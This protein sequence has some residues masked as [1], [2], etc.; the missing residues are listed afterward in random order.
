MTSRYAIYFAPEPDSAFEQAGSLCLGR[1]ARTGWS[2]EPLPVAGIPKARLQVINAPPR[3]YGFHGTLKAP[4]HLN[5]QFIEANLVEAIDRLASQIDAFALPPLAVKCLGNFIA[6]VPQQESSD[7]RNLAER[8][9]S[10]LDAFRAPMTDSDRARRNP[11]RL[12]LQQRNNLDRWGYPYVFDEFRFHMT[13]SGP[14]EVGEASKLIEAYRI[15]LEPVLN[16]LIQA[17][18]ITLFVQKEPDQPFSIKQRFP[19]KT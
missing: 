10:D 4:F 7:L 17:D 9:V 18:A 3:R 14:V 11:D 8:C 15:V 16:M 13:L 5:D 19:L 1:N 2:D 12:T 6:L